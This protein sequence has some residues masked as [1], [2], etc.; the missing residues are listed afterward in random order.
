MGNDGSGCAHP[1]PRHPVVEDGDVHIDP[2]I[3]PV[4]RG[5]AV[6]RSVDAVDPRRQLPP[7]SLHRP[8][9]P[10]KRT[11]G[12]RRRSASWRRGVAWGGLRRS[13]AIPSGAN[14]SQYGKGGMNVIA[15]GSL[16]ASSA[17]ASPAMPTMTVGRP[18]I[19]A[20]YKVT[21]RVRRRHRRAG[22]R[23]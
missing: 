16:R 4:N 5:G 19:G 14:P 7:K 13:S 1:A 21:A 10:V 8:V 15:M 2:I 17:V 6:Q 22:G 11:V 9:L 3:A 18:M 23:R 12:S 20:R